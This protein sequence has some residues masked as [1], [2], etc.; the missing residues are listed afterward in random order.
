M[1]VLSFTSDRFRNIGAAD[2]D[3][4]AVI[5][6]LKAKP[7][8]NKRRPLHSGLLTF[9]LSLPLTVLLLVMGLP[10]K[11][12]GSPKGAFLLCNKDYE[13]EIAARREMIE[14]NPSIERISFALVASTIPNILDAITSKPSPARMY[15]L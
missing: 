4:Y 7:R 11:L 13:F 1:V 5:G 6:W 10:P 2:A 9:I 3:S 8:P 12:K 15:V 14:L